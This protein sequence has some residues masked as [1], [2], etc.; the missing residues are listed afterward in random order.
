MVSLWDKKLNLD[1]NEVLF[2]S[3]VKT[4]NLIKGYPSKIQVL[5][6]SVPAQ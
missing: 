1:E 4:I 6:E 2:H 3:N 5:A